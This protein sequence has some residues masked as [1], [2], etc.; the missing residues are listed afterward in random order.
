MFIIYHSLVMKYMI[1]IIFHFNKELFISFW[2]YL[3]KTPWPET[4]INIIIYISLITTLQIFF[5]CQYLIIMMLNYTFSFY[6][7][8]VS[9]SD[10]FYGL[11]HYAFIPL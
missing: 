10:R 11:K 8:G 7:P 2:F 6:T 3:F 9:E 5:L 1:I 4:G